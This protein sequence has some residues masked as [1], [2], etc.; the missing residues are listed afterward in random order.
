VGAFGFDKSH[1]HP[2]LL[3]PVD[4]DPVIRNTVDVQKPLILPDTAVAKDWKKQADTADVNSWI[5]DLLEH[6]LHRE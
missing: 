1:P 2:R 3:R 4:A 5:F 6:S